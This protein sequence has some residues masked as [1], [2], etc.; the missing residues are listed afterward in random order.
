MRLRKY[1]V[2]ILILICAACIQQPPEEVFEPPEP[3]L[4]TTPETIAPETPPPTEPPTS[5]PPPEPPE[6][7]DKMDLWDNKTGPH[8]RGANI[9]QR[10]VYPELD[11]PTFYG[12]GPVGT[13]YTQ[14]DFDKLAS[15]GCNY[16][17]I[18]HPGLFT[19]KPPYKLD[20]EI[21]DNLDNLLEMIEKADMFAVISFRTGPGRSEFTFMADDVGD[22][23][24]ESY[25]NDTV[26]QDKEAQDAWVAMWK[27]TAN[28]YKDNPIIAGFDLMVEPN[29]NETGSDY[30]HD[31]L[32]IWDPEEFYADYGGT[33]Y[34]WNQLYPRI[35]TA[36]RK[37][38]K[39]T[40]ILVGGNGYSN[41]E[42]LPYVKV[43][44]DPR[45]VYIL[46]QYAPH[47]YTHQEYTSIECSYPGMCDTDW[48]DRKEQFDKNWLVDLLSTVDIFT[49]THKVPV[50]VNEFGVIRWVPG[51]AQFMDG[52]MGI[53]EEKGMNSALWEWQSS[54]RAFYKEVNA[55]NF[56][57]GPDPHN[58]E[59]VDNDLLQ[60]IKRYWS[61]NTVRP[62]TFYSVTPSTPVP[63]E[64]QPPKSRSERLAAVKY[65]FYFLDVNLEP[66]IIEKIT[67]SVYDMVVI[68][69]I[70][71]DIENTDYPMA[72]VVQRMRNASHPKLVIAY[73]D[74]GEAEDYRT[75]W[76]P[77]WRVGDPEWIAGDDPDGWEG[78]YP[79]AFWHEA[80]RNIWL[81]NTGLLQ[82][83]LDAGFDGVY[84]DW[85]EA[86]SDENVMEIA[87]DDGVDPLREMITWVK[88]IAEFTRSQNPD[89][90]VIAQNASELSEYTDY[91]SIIDAIAQEQV[92]FDGGADDEPPGD[93]PLPRTEDDI[94][95]EEYYSSLS[96]ACQNTYDR[97]PD[98][99]LHTSS[100]EYI[101]YLTMAQLKGKI[102]FTVDYALNP[103][104]VAW[105]Y[106]TS[107]A[108]GF[109]PFVSN[110]ALN[111]YLE[112]VLV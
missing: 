46:H 53:F 88:D 16:V 50:A 112:P 25:L 39:D 111:I 29:S 91:L 74:I 1:S 67:N 33:L 110:R 28:R 92:W 71:S 56:L 14:E 44:S 103:E 97:Y 76:Q 80:W 68:E 85:V 11:G 10:R 49:T 48:D 43:L 109:I 3:T 40:P 51:A 108:L 73:I 36:I 42:W 83:I 58:T 30:M 94:D 64:L 95:T 77:D 31:Y 62:S 8:L 4:P 70:P 79:V 86:Y 17:N 7:P 106:K 101:Y 69:Y 13:P 100:E 27:Y 81:G 72:S 93:C 52:E 55:F 60:V 45:I 23:F 87:E 12:P 90:I 98:S 102:I 54:W 84:L 2:L 18:S 61:Y 37:I 41:I 78:N 38:D 66:D 99:T 26:W 22:W 104:N 63:E 6:P 19:E 59:E 24:D 65:W 34:D 89:F 105:V 35:I 96:E 32:D 20:K 5:P 57:F 21:Q 75:Y 15:L 47:Q 9:H 82:G 107:R